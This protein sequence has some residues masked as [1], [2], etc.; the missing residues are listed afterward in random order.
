MGTVKELCPL[1]F[2]LAMPAIAGD[3]LSQP[4]PTETARLPVLVFRTDGRPIVDRTHIPSTL[5]LLSFN[6][7]AKSG[8]AKVDY[9]G[10]A[11]LSAR[12][13]SSYYFEKKSYRLELQTGS[14]RDRKASLLGMPADSD[15]VL[16]GSA[17]DRSFARDILAH[18]LWRRMGHYAVRWRYVE[19][20]LIT[21][22]LVKA[23]SLA[24]DLGKE[25]PH[26]LAALSLNQPAAAALTFSNQQNRLGSVLADS[27]IGLYLL[28]E[29][30]KRGKDRVDVVK[31]RPT[32]N[33]EPEISGGYILKKDDRGRNQ[34]GL[35][36]GQEFRVRYE[37]PKESELTAVQKQWMAKYL[38]DFE[39]ALMGPNFRDIANGYPKYIDIESFVD[40]HWLVELGK[41]ADGFSFSQYIHKDR[42]RPLSMGPVWDWDNAFGNPYFDL[43]R[44]TNGWRFETT[45]ENDYS[46]Y[47]RLFD[48]PDFLQ[49]YIDRWSELRATILATSNVLAIVDG[50]ANQLKGAHR[51]N[52]LRWEQE[53]RQASLRVWVGISY[54]DE[55]TVLK[56]W[57]TTRLN[58]IDSE[59]FPKPVANVK[60]AAKFGE[61]QVELTCSAGRLFYTTN[62]ADP[63]ARGGSVSRTAAEY[64]TPIAL[65][66]NLVIT[67]RARSDF[68]L[69]SARTIIQLLQ[70][71]ADQAR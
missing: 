47:R 67:A 30:I 26:V 10:Q 29:K 32:D 20:F 51:R 64:T 59:A 36:T 9:E 12:G 61:F 6:D 14:G 31:L 1:L 53:G 23:P 56:N 28:M 55:L 39:K 4:T 34:R 7:S 16:Y 60:H 38:E 15:W 24:Q 8:E 63:R 57:I 3:P 25:V 35:L 37:E 69:W 13:N 19:V 43:I 41:N 48:D 18:E 22:Q 17:T 54:M 42:G 40:F 49:R 11:E 21:N 27:Y 62:G 50:V 2:C 65:P 52:S 58:W 66:P 44:N 5:Q 33:A 46:W 45:D 68:G 70:S 71:H